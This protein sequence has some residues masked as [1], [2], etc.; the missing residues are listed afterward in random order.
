MVGKNAQAQTIVVVEL[1]G[2]ATLSGLT[3]ALEDAATP[4]R[5]QSPPGV[6]AIL[7]GKAKPGV[8]PEQ[9]EEALKKAGITE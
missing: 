2:K 1:S 7:P 4:H 5:A 8:T 3:K 9:I 6:A